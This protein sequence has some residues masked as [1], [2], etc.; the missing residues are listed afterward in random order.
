MK[1]KQN[2]QEHDSV[3]YLSK[4]LSEEKDKDNQGTFNNN[5]LRICMY[6]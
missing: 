5:L 3:I 4:I 6:L 2:N 1:E